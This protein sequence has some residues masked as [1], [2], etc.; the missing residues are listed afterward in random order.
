[1]VPKNRSNLTFYSFGGRSSMNIARENEVVTP[2]LL[3]NSKHL[4][5]NDRHAVREF[6]APHV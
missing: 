6:A 2:A 3:S 5:T 1:L 4:N